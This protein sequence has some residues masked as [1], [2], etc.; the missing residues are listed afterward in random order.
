VTEFHLNDA[1]S[2]LRASREA[3]KQSDR[4]IGRLLDEL[5]TTTAVSL[6]TKMQQLQLQ[7][8]KIGEQIRTQQG[9]T[10]KASDDYNQFLSLVERHLVSLNELNKRQAAWKQAMERLQDLQSSEL[11]LKGELKEAQDQLSSLDAN[12]A[13]VSLSTKIQQLQ[14]QIDQVGEQ[15]GTQQ[16][17]TTK[18]SDDY[19][20]FTSLVERHL[21]SVNELNPH[22][23]AW[24]H[25]VE[26][27]QDLQNSE[28]RLK[29]ELKKA[30]DQLSSLNANR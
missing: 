11:R 28:L 13:A 21:V 24:N 15:I 4:T 17:F 5:H 30:K 23:A 8:D 12:S 14:L 22:Q 9:F 16:G 6:S 27:L 25:A 7:I 29:G 3:Q 18:A 19:N 1:L 26:R 20:L 10:T 2:E